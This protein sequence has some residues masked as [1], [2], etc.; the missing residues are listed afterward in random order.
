MDSSSPTGAW[1]AV[2]FGWKIV[3]FYEDSIG[4]LVKSENE[5]LEVQDPEVIYTVDLKGLNDKI[6]EEGLNELD[7]AL[8][9]E[10]FYNEFLDLYLVF[11]SC[12]TS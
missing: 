9:L 10:F 3:Y 12:K 5:F 4:N 1:K 2:L 8:S 11:Q 6:W 7:S